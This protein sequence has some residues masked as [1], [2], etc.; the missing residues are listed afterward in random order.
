MEVS[1][2]E[3][4]T[5]FVGETSRGISTHYVEDCERGISAINMWESVSGD[6]SNQHVGE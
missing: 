2:R 5:H 4:S 3:I 6:I 1:N